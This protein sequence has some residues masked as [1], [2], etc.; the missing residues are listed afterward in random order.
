MEKLMLAIVAL[1]FVVMLT[2]AAFL[3]HWEAK[4]FNKFKSPDQPKA[5]Y[6]DAV[7][8]ELRV[9]TE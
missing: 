8:C 9:D 5:T 7:C 1:I 3:P 4:A 6:W 2:V